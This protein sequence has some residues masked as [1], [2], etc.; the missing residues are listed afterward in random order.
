MAERC[1]AKCHLCWL[2]LMLSVTY[3]PF[4]LSVVMLNVIMLGVVERFLKGLGCSRLSNY[5]PYTKLETL[6]SHIPLTVQVFESNGVK[7]VRLIQV[8]MSW[9][10]LFDTGTRGKFVGECSLTNL[11]SI[12][13]CSREGPGATVACSFEVRR[14]FENWML[15]RKHWFC[16]EGETVIKIMILLPYLHDPPSI[17]N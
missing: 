9:N 1:C 3:I 12:A 17:P 4:L 2:S 8:P 7:F 16:W 6:L 13:Q 10:V 15:C 14:V 5:G 11:L